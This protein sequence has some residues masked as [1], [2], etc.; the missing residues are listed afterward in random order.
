MG[1]VRCAGSN[2]SFN[3]KSDPTTLAISTDSSRPQQ[4][5]AVIDIGVMGCYEGYLR[6]WDYRS[7]TPGLTPE[8]SPLRLAVVLSGSI[9]NSDFP[10]FS[11][12]LDTRPTISLR[13]AL[14]CQ[15]DRPG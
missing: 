15:T 7:Y 10:G 1:P 12:R 11:V 9:G 8:V 5:R 6:C 14:N 2:T 3:G 4:V 13:P